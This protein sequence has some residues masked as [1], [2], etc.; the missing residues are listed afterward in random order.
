MVADALTSGL[1]IVALLAGRYLSWTWLDPATGILGG[2][3]ILK[4]SIGLCKHAAFDL[5][6]VDPSREVERRVEQAI[7]TP[8]DA[9]IADLHV[10]SLGQGQRACVVT[11]VAEAPFDAAA[12]QARLI[13][14]PLAHVTIEV[15]RPPR[16]D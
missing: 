4:W 8:G 10:W 16:Q 13:G 2:L 12:C 9:R 15:R 7:E 5:V 14:L 3:V 1:A 6:D 11:V